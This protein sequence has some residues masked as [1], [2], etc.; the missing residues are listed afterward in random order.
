MNPYASLRGKQVVLYTKR[1]AKY[2]GELHPYGKD[3]VALRG[4]R[5]YFYADWLDFPAVV[6]KTK[7]VRKFQIRNILKVVEGE[8]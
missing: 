2:G 3:R 5:I 6:S 7:T 8:L 4:L 1:G